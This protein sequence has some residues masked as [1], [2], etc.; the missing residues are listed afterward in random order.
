MAFESGI[1]GFSSGTAGGIADAYR[2]PPGWRWSV[3]LGLAH[4]GATRPG[5]AADRIGPHPVQPGLSGGSGTPPTTRL[6]P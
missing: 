4:R 5:R 2:L 3:R 6:F 1:L